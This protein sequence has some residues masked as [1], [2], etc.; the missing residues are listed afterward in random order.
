[1]VSQGRMPLVTP[2]PE[3]AEVE[4][5]LARTAEALQEAR[6]RLRRAGVVQRR[7]EERLVA[8]RFER[9]VAAV[10]V[11]ELAELL[12]S[13]QQELALLHDTREPRTIRVS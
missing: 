5:R 3:C 13:L 7:A 12:E 8:A 10:E 2:T 11:G 4:R 6:T 1:M 9:E